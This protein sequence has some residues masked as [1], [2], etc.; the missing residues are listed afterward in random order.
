[1]KKLLL[2]SS[3]I[4]LIFLGNSPLKAQS[5]TIPTGTLNIGPVLLGESSDGSHTFTVTGSGYSSGAEL[6]VDANDSRFTLSTSSTGPFIQNLTYYADGSG[7]VN[8]AIYVKYTPTT[9]GQV[10]TNLEFYDFESFTWQYKEVRGIGK[11]PEIL[12]EG[13]PSGSD[14]WNEIVNGETTPSIAEGTDF[15]DA[16]TGSGNV[17]RIYQISNTS[18][19]G[20]SGNLVLDEYETGKYAE[21]S[22][23][24]ADQFSVTIEPSTPVAPSGST[25][26]TIKF[27]PTSAGVKN[28]TV[29]IG[30]NDP[31]E[32]PYTFAIKGNG[33]LLLPDS[34]TADAA[35]TI[36]HNSFYAN[37]TVG[38]GGVT[39]GYYLDVATNIGFTNF[40]PGYNGLDVGLVT[41]YQV[42]GLSSN[43][44]YFYRLRAYNSSGSSGFSNTITLKT[45]PAVPVATAA[46][47]INAEN[48]YANWGFVDGATSYRLDVNTQPNF[49]GTAILDN[50]IVTGT[51]KNVTG[52]TGGTTYYYRVR[53]YN[54]NVS[55]NSNIITAI[56]YCNAP[57]AT[58]ATNVLNSSFTANWTPPAGGA[59]D[60]YKLDVSTSSS[61]VTFLPGYSNLTVNGT[62]QSVTGL[63]QNTIYYY[64]VRSVNVAGSSENSNTITVQ[65][66]G[67]TSWTGS[68]NSSWDLPGNWDNGVPGPNTDVTVVPGF[69]QPILNT[70]QACNDLTMEA[71][72]ELTIVAGKTLN[73]NGDFLMESNALG[74]AS[75]VEYGGLNVSGSSTIEKFFTK[76]RWHYLSPTMSGQLSGVFEDIYLKYWDEPSQDWEYITSLTYPLTEGTG[77]AAWNY[78]DNVTVYYTG[79]TINQGPYNPTITYT[80]TGGYNLIGNPYP[81]GI[82]WDEGSWTKTNIDGT[83]YVWNGTQNITWNGSTG[84]L[85]N[86]IIPMGQAFSV[87]ANGANPEIVMT[88]AARGHSPFEP[89]KE[90]VTNLIKMFAYGNDYEDAAYINF[91]EDATD[92]FDNAYDGYKRWGINEAPQLFTVANDINLAVNVLGELTENKIIQV[93]YRVGVAGE[94]TIEVTNMESFVDPVTIYL[95]D[96]MTGEMI[97]VADQPNYTFAASPEDDIIRFELHFTTTVGIEDQIDN[98][99]VYIYSSGNSVYVRSNENIEAGSI[100][101]FNISGLE[102]LAKQLEGIPLNK[103]D[104]AVETGYYF[105]R[106]TTKDEVYSQKVFIR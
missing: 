104:L 27:T 54:G 66:P 77:Y 68:V 7:N 90:E 49:M 99:N 43:T 81:S 50:E 25:T 97:N 75:L 70:N 57:T 84:S 2:L 59:P 29:S 42:T 53:S 80:S 96:L 18:T 40:V 52:L 65:L 16:L 102:I 6:Y 61:F 44:D 85:T 51:F 98:S 46:T 74:N 73:V 105:V 56:T 37:W 45:A 87:R 35:T 32:N 88:D 5:L 83:V 72:S 95:K 31:N 63:S 15:G 24:G 91:V 82:D 47:N 93:G 55:G 58:A 89:Y 23:P 30:N 12:L 86:G 101:V 41:T 20:L 34:P 14:P 22:G 64:R 67:S 106:V 13:R 94:Y 71:S 33:T 26:F 60:S 36:N 48:F 11:G 10:L 8:Q 1:M 69:N 4:L 28:A 38:A 17:D 3:L 19:G 100:K 78:D 92:G 76:D 39:T 79:G 62:F 103:I 21:I 9:I